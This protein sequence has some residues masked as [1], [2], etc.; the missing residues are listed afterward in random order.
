M[1]VIGVRARNWPIRDGQ[2]QA[3]LIATSVAGIVKASSNG[4]D[5]NQPSPSR[6]R[7]PGEVII[8]S[9]GQSPTKRTNVTGDPH[10][11]IALFGPRATNQEPLRTAVIS[12][13]ASAKPP[14][15]DYHDL[16]A[17]EDSPP[18]TDPSKP[19][20][21][22][23][24]NKPSA[25]VIA[26]KGGAGKH[27][28]PSRLFDDEIPPPGTPGA[29]QQSPDRFK[30][31]H[32]KKYDHFD[33]GDDSDTQVQQQQKHSHTSPVRPKSKHESQ[34]GSEDFVTPDKVAPSKI[35]GQDV[36]HFGWSDDEGANVESPVKHPKVVQPRRDAQAN[37]EF[38]DHGTPGGDQRPPG[39]PRGGQNRQNGLGLYEN[40]VYDDE[41]LPSSPEKKSAPLRTVTNIKDRKKDFDP[42][43]SMADNSPSAK[44]NGSNGNRIMP[45]DGQKAIKTMDARGDTSDH[46]RG[47]PQQSTKENYST[48][49]NSSTMSTGIKTGGDGMGGKKGG[50]A[51]SW[52]FG[53]DSDGEVPG[54]VNRGKFFADK[55]QQAPKEQNLWN[56]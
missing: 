53:D 37:F 12:P 3:R 24:E 40:N 48:G 36:R 20:S 17:G 23:K 4:A 21:P 39:H 31:P 28:Q 30:K 10:A 33:F 45:D 13:R 9:K 15:R 11:S 2:D 1:D 51:R 55:K 16:F 47:Q 14:P 32:P 42:H 43:F 34:W 19:D 18:L 6:S 49:P 27:Y 29:S 5:A 52:G 8:T 7:N 35:R 22:Q 26:P 25:N 46:P 44:D 38:K 41:S 54:G 56:F 50:P